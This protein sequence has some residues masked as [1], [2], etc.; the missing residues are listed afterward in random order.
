M[1][2]KNLNAWRI[3]NMFIKLFWLFTKNGKIK[4]LFWLLKSRHYQLNLV[5]FADNIQS[6]INF[7]SVFCVYFQKNLIGG[8]NCIE[9]YKINSS[10]VKLRTN[11]NVVPKRSESSHSYKMKKTLKNIKSR[12]TRFW[13][14]WNNIWICAKLHITWIFL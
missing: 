9:F 3:A 2:I 13:S 1:S 5:I 8:K 10:D 6:S 12:I 7:E 14:F 4:I 11:S